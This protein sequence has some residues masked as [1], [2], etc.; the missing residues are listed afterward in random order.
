MSALA[1]R[2]PS[3]V[4]DDAGLAADQ[5]A[6]ALGAVGTSSAQAERARARAAQTLAQLRAEQQDP[7]HGGAAAQARG[8]AN[9]AHQQA[10]RAWAS[11]ALQAAGT[12]SAADE[13][14]P[15]TPDLLAALRA[16]P[17]RQLV[18]ATGLSP[19]YLSRIRLGKTTPHP[20]WN[21]VLHQAAGEEPPGDARGR[22]GR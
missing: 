13:A 2:R 21:A 18:Q 5:Q 10:I 20:R 16:R 4:G 22:S 14:P 8:A 15:L 6:D 17:L 1:L 12:A 7:A 11:T 3:T 9:A 19:A